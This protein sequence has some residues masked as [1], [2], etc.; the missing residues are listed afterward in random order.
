M[1]SD[2]RVT[3]PLADP[4]ATAALGHWLGAHLTAGQ[5]VALIGEMGAG[6][7]TLTRGLARGL[8]V[9]D[10]DAVA[11]PTYLLVIEHPGPVPLIHIDAWLPEKTR[12]FLEDGGVDYL[13]ERDGVV[14]VEWADRLADLL[15]AEATLTVRLEADPMGSGGRVADLTGGAEFTWIDGAPGGRRPSS[16]ES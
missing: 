12:G 14:V 16:R 9:E 11:S 1:P 15:P 8:G 10:P 6:K 5:A 4:E 3:V 7:T 2:H 13:A